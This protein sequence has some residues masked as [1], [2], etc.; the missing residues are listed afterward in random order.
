MVEPFQKL[1][2]RLKDKVRIMNDTVIRV[3]TDVGG[4]F[5]DLVYVE[6]NKKQENRK[7]KQ[8]KLTDPPPLNWST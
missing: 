8:L 3:A 2:L 6:F 7:S 5:T 1:S 4:T